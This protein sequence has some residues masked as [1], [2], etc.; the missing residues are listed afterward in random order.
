MTVTHPDITRYFMSIRE[1]VELVIQAGAMAQGG[2]VF[3][4]DMGEPVKIVDLARTMI[5]LAGYT[6][7]DENESEDGIAIEFT[8]LRPGEKLFEELLIGGDTSPTR[9][10]RIK[11]LDEPYIPM[12]DLKDE[13]AMLEKSMQ[14]EDIAELKQVIERLVEGYHYQPPC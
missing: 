12:A 14:E 9:H 4:L 13:L 5:N 10:P 6:I 1:A 7:E 3:V 2:E 8:G 11:Q